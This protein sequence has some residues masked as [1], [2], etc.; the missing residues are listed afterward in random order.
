VPTLLSPGGLHSRQRRRLFR[1]AAGPPLAKYG[2]R[3]AASEHPGS[4]EPSGDFADARGG[5]GEVAGLTQWIAEVDV[6]TV[7][8]EVAMPTGRYSAR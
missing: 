2:R 1:P 3:I 6:L 7:E 5:R 4:P 8:R